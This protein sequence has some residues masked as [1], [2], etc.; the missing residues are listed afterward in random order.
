MTVKEKVKKKSLHHPRPKPTEMRMFCI[1]CVK[2]ERYGLRNK[3]IRNM[4]GLEKIEEFLREQRLR[5]FRH[6]E[7]IDN[8]RAT[9]KAKR[10]VVESSKKAPIY[11]KIEKGLDK[12]MLIRGLKQN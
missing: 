3:T 5:W 12:D 7:R 6:V 1:I 8:E 4:T 10:F 2:T 11:E 9:V